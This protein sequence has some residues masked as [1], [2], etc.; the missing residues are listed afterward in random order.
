MDLPDRLARQEF[1]AYFRRSRTAMLLVDDE[2]RY[3]AINEAAC[4][5]LGVEAADLIGMT[6]D[7]LTP[8]EDRAQIPGLW[9]AF[10]SEGVLEGPYELVLPS[11]GRRLL[12][13]LSAT[14]NVE[15]SMHLSLMVPAGESDTREARPGAGGGTPIS[16]R[17]LEVLRLVAL[18]LANGEIASQLGISPETVRNHVRNARDKLG[19]RTKAH[20]VALAFQR[21]L[22]EH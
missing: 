22:F 20:A 5:L 12:V 2:R 10:L 1:S 9:R 8:P 3:V 17:E 4:R 16:P 21:R 18:G 7:D 6:I 15:T 19:A 14:A 11:D 13:N